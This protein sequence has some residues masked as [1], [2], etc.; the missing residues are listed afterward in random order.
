MEHFQLVGDSESSFIQTDN[1][2][3]ITVITNFLTNN[4]YSPYIVETPIGKRNILFNIGFGNINEI[5]LFLPKEAFEAAASGIVNGAGFIPIDKSSDTTT[6]STVTTL[7]ITGSSDTT[8][9]ETTLPETTLPETTQPETTVPETTLPETTTEP[10]TNIEHFTLN[11]S[12]LKILLIFA[13]LTVVLYLLYSKNKKFV[14]KF[15]K[16]TFKSMKKFTK[17]LLKKIKF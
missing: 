15:L 1:Y 2:D 16:Q 9:P 12:R 3:G 4:K 6:T 5:E 8:V 13:L 11:Y 14:D 17:P 10:F 7:P